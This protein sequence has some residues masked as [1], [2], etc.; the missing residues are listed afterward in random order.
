MVARTRMVTAEV[1]KFW[2]YFEVE[3]IRFPDR[4]CMVH[5][6]QK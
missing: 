4:F 2:M 6:I 5:E 3:M 1:V